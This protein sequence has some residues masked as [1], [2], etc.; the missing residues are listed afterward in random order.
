MQGSN[1]KKALFR[2]P[3]VLFKD[4]AKLSSIS[5]GNAE[6]PPLLPLLL[7]EVTPNTALQTR[8]KKYPRSILPLLD[9]AALLLPT[10][11]KL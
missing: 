1:F 3:Q 9:P 10:H 6:M 4:C 7:E 8:L 2:V 11:K 5:D